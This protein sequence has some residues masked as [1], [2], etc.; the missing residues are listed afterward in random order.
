MKRECLFSVVAHKDH[1]P[2][3]RQGDLVYCD[4]EIV[5]EQPVPS[6][7]NPAGLFVGLSQ[8]AEILWIGDAPKRKKGGVIYQVRLIEK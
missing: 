4:M 2:F 6:V 3:L 7:K 5:T 8:D 1:L